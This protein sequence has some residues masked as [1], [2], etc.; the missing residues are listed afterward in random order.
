[1]QHSQLF[2][3]FT[4]LKKYVFFVFIGTKFHRN[5]MQIH[6]IQI[7]VSYHTR[8]ITSCSRFH[9]ITHSHSHICS[10]Q[11]TAHRRIYLEATFRKWTEL[12]EARGTWSKA[13]A[14]SGPIRPLHG[15]VD[16]YLG[17]CVTH[18]RPNTVGKNRGAQLSIFFHC[19]LNLL[20]SEK[21]ILTRHPWMWI[22]LFSLERVRFSLHILKQDS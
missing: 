10:G 18:L 11:S 12:P 21:C 16:Q 5:Y 7:H 6:M 20:I 14:A 15:H 22:C 1:M 17:T 9:L 13:V 19:L 4:L 8:P 2:V 3:L